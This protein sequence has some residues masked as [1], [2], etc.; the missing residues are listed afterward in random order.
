MGLMAK[1]DFPHIV[2]NKSVMVGDTLT[3]MIF[4]NRLHMITVLIDNKPY[5]AQKYPKL[6]HFRC[7]DLVHFA[8]LL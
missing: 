8:R 6:I 4:G 3:D 1:K 5:L 7:K 2:F